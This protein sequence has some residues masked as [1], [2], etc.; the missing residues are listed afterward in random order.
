MT[1]IKNWIKKSLKSIV[2]AVIFTGALNTPCQAQD[3]AILNEILTATNNI[4]AAVQ[5]MPGLIQGYLTSDLKDIVQMANNLNSTTDPNNII[6]TNQTNFTTVFNDY[7]TAI[8]QQ[9]TLGQTLTQLYMTNNNK[10]SLPT[11]ANELNYG[12]LQ[13]QLIAPPADPAQKPDINSLA[14]NY[15]MH[16]SG[17]EFSLEPPTATWAASKAKDQYIALFNITNSI[18]SYNNYILSSLS[19]Q[20]DQDTNRLTL[21]KQATDPSFFFSNIQTEN[22]GLVIRQIL[23]Y[24]S[25]LYVVADRQLKIQQQQLAATAMTNSLLLIFAGYQAGQTIKAQA[26]SASG[27]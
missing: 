4:L 3:E 1:Q 19:Q 22:L 7:N 26:G 10:N 18:A 5:A 16:A 8:G 25:Q 24:V 2:L 20:Q 23:M 12:I 14:Q 17:I 27:S 6:G 11:N 13:G 21:M 9:Q 15:L